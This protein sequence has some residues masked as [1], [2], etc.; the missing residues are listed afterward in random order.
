M[1]IRSTDRIYSRVSM[2][3]YEREPK[4]ILC[5]RAHK[6]RFDPEGWPDPYSS[7][8]MRCQDGDEPSDGL[9]PTGV[10]GIIYPPDSLHPEV[11]NAAVFRELSPMR[12]MFDSKQWRS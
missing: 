1:M 11:T 2:G 4:H 9:F 8:E 5:Y 10:G 6:M 7:W 3:A 12:M